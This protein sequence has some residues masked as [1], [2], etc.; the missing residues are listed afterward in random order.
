MRYIVYAQKN[1]NSPVRIEKYYDEPSAIT[2]YNWFA[3]NNYYY[4]LIGKID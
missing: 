2:A 3:V 4:I 1:F